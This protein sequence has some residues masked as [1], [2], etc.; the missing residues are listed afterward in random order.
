MAYFLYGEAL[1]SQTFF[2]K[3]TIKQ[4]DYQALLGRDYR[5]GPCCA[6][7]DGSIPK[8]GDAARMIAPSGLPPVMPA[9]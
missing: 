4:R 7:A 9:P 6:T 5:G 8:L 1:V 2:N 3:E